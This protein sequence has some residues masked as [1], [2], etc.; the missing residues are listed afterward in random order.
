[1]AERR[2]FAK[3]IIDSDAFLDMPCSSQAL[4]FHLIIRAM[5]NGTLNNASH[6]CLSVGCELKDLTLLINKGYVRQIEENIYEITN[7]DYVTGRGETAKKRITYKYRKWRKGILNRDSYTCQNCGSKENL[8]VHHIKSFAEHE[9]ERY[10]T[11]NGITLCRK[12]HMALHKEERS[13]N[14]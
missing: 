1:M 7:W 12:C 13:K 9:E 10:S 3:T 4:Y 5:D 8:E 6:T 2:M 14:V 11:E